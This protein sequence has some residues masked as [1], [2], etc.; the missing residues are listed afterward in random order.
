MSVRPLL[1]RLFGAFVGAHP[2]HRLRLGFADGSGLDLFPD[3]GSPGIEIVFRTRAAER[4]SLVLFYAGLFDAYVAGDVEIRGDQ[5]LLRLAEMG[6]DAFDQLARR[7]RLARLAGYNP[8]VRLMQIAQEARQNNRDLARAKA[9]A[10]FHYGLPPRFFELILGETVGYSEGYWPEGTTTLDQAKFNNYDLVCRK[11]MLRPGLKVAEVGAGWGWMPIHMAKAYGAEVTVL[12]PVPRQNDYMR[13]RFA[14]H[15]L[16][17]RIR[18]F[19]RDH[20]ELALEPETYDRYVSIGVYEHVGKDGYDAWIGSIAAAL[21]PGG[22]GVL[23]TTAKMRREM[24]EYLTLKYVFP[25]GHIPSLP[26]TLQTMGAHGLKVVDVENLWPHYRRTV[27]C[28]LAN[29]ESRW[30]EITR[31]DPALFDERFRRIWTMYLSGTVASFGGFIDLYHI[32]F[33]KGRDPDAHPW[34]RGRVLAGWQPA[35]GPVPIYP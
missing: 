6:V 22:L 15:G 25:G 17:D 19:E 14:R 20:R 21:K 5:A 27:A 10:I 12:N 32:V 1:V 34:D 3:G 31:I 2:R 23:S 16:A 9:N 7:G 4:R 18:L 35:A 24:T 30:P 29:L 33:V 11:L 13:A 28:W 26:L 8:I